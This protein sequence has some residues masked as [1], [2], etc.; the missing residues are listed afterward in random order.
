MPDNDTRP[1]QG[2]N[3][4]YIDF[5]D[6]PQT[7]EHVQAQ[8]EAEGY[9]RVDSE[10]IT[11][12]IEQCMQTGQDMPEYELIVLVFQRRSETRIGAYRIDPRFSTYRQQNT[13]DLIRNIRTVAESFLMVKNIEKQASPE[14]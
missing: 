11:Q 3:S 1:L 2:E 7:T 5:E 13:I 14:P 10:A 12:R 9:R 4:G 6:I 8:L